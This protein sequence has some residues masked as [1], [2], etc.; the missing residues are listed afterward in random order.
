MSEVLVYIGKVFLIQAL[1]YGFYK[2]VLKQ[3]LRHSWNRFYLLSVLILSFGIPFIETPYQQ[4]IEP[5]NTDY[6]ITWVQESAMEYELTPIINTSE[7]TFNYWSVLPWLYGVIV[8]YLI[9]R[10]VAYLFILQKLKKHSE[11]VKKQW[12]K[13]FKISQPRPFSFFS[14]VFI[15]EQ[16]FGTSSF[17][18]ILAHE[19]VH[20]KQWHSYDRLL[21]D[22]LVSLFW[23][24]PFIYWY[25]NA[26]IEI[27][28]FQADAAVIRR[29]K[30][31]VGYQEILF[32]QLQVA[33]YSGLVSHFNFSIIKKRIVMMNKQKNKYAGWVYAL[34]MPVVLSVI[35]AFS[36]REAIEPIEKVG[37]ELAD[38]LSPQPGFKFPGFTLPEPKATTQDNTT[39]S[40]LP[41]KDTE[42]V[43]MTSGFGTRYDPIDKEEK[44][45][46]GM[47]LATPIGNPVLATADGK[48][49]LAKEDG[50]HGQRVIIKHNDTFTS[51]Y[52]HLS[53]IDVKEGESVKKGDQI[54]LSGNSGASTA[55]HL[56]YEIQKDDEYVNPIYYIGDY[57]F[58]VKTEQGELMEAERQKAMRHAER[59]QAE[60][61]MMIAKQEAEQARINQI[62][63]QEAQNLASEEQKQAYQQQKEAEERRQVEE[64]IREEKLKFEDRRQ[65]RGETRI[66]IDGPGSTSLSGKNPP[67]YVVDGEIRDNVEEMDPNK[68]ERIE[69]LKGES[70][71]SKY[72]EKG[73]DGVIEIT[74]KD[75][76]K[77]KTKLKEKTKDKDKEKL[78]NE[79]ERLAK[80]Y[81]FLEG[82]DG[83][84]FNAANWNIV[85][86]DDM[87]KLKRVG[88]LEGIV[89]YNA[90]FE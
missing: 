63:A 10:S 52:S 40:I 64:K 49:E 22:F 44:L 38:I 37:T 69:V 48:V 51:A 81:G 75:K 82:Y 1:F 36:T 57:N 33:S 74:T 17:D 21:M 9:S 90:F 86:K 59:Q 29:F 67:L 45:H 70:A 27:H 78:K 71:T 87:V 12:F 72:G 13:L 19:C 61:E 25:R 14:N 5:L 41:L 28:E 62:Q 83:D 2:L 76:K 79:Q 89:L 55:P 18:Q 65:A 30:D 23:F 8:C 31:P 42:N 60:K 15:P 11:Y 26:L 68:I 43:R 3:S 34:T 32:S 20:V 6:V 77:E 39:P 85:L 66:T 50:K 80:V 35:F 84:S 58:K 88:S 7:S 53:S 46:K 4:A 24:N 56:H 54:G 47:D 16:I 73:S